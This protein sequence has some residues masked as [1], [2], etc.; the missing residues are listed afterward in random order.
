M[1]CDIHI[2]VEVKNEKR[3]KWEPLEGS[4]E[5]EEDDGEKYMNIGPYHSDW[6]FGRDYDSFAVMADVRN[7]RGFAGVDT[8]D[9]FEVIDRPRGIPTDASE[10]YKEVCEIWEGDGHSHSFLYLRELKEWYNNAASKTT[11]HRG[12]V[13][14]SYYRKMKEEGKTSPDSWCDGI[15]GPGV[16]VMDTVRADKFIDE[17]MTEADGASYHVKIEWEETYLNSAFALKCYIEKLMEI[18]VEK[19]LCHNCVRVCF[20][21]DN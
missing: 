10:L 20:F 11:K 2:L 15:S 14:L 7:G 1:G 18:E 4:Y 6:Y 12:I 19:N 13:D 21:F 17:E 3:Y 5:I 9:G 8:G 16:V